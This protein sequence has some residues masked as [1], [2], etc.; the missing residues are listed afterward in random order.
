[1]KRVVPV[2]ISMASS[3][4]WSERGIS[5]VWSALTWI[6]VTVVVIAFDDES[7]TIGLGKNVLDA[8]KS[9]TFPAAIVRFKIGL[10][11]DRIH[12]YIIQQKA[13]AVQRRVGDVFKTD[14]HLLTG[15]LRKIDFLVHPVIGLTVVAPA[16]GIPGWILICAGRRSEDFPGLSTSWMLPERHNRNPSRGHTTSRRTC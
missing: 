10:I 5:A 13:F 12:S 7:Q 8:D 9:G 11:V 4:F 3:P 6:C 16:I 1:M 15:K 2:T 14:L